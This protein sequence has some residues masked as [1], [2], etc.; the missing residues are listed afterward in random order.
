ML[1]MMGAFAEFE[2]S[3]IRER[4]REGIVAAQKAGKRFGRKKALSDDQIADIRERVSMGQQKSLIA[5]E[6]CISRTT[7]Y[8]ALAN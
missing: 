6:Y 1:Q 5:A 8:A 3:L 4:Q 2:R 7:L